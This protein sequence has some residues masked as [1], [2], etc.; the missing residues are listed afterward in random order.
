MREQQ[1]TPQTARILL[2]LV[3]N[4][5]LSDFDPDGPL[6]SFE[7]AVDAPPFIQGRARLESDLQVWADRLRAVAAEKNLSRRAR[8]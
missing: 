6:P 2:E 1:V 4:R 7:P 5:D 8:S 3:W